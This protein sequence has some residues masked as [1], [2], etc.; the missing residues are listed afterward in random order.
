M[1]L[2][3]TGIELGRWD[4]IVL[5]YPTFP[6]LSRLVEIC[7]KIR[8]VLNKQIDSCC[9]TDNLQTTDAMMEKLELYVYCDNSVNK[10]GLYNLRSVD[11]AVKSDKA[12][13]GFF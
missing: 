8:L 13:R 6:I 4:R 5:F 3:A 10:Y 2:V 7:I 9:I 1:Q 12:H 11:N